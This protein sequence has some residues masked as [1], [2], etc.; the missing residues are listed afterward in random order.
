VTPPTVPEAGPQPVERLQ[1][2]AR[3]PDRPF[4]YDKETLRA[5]ES[6]PSRC[7]DGNCDLYGTEHSH[8]EQSR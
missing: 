4:S 2:A 8:Q 6:D 3:G 1:E 7:Y 5:M